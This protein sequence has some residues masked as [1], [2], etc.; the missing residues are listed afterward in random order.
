M[1]TIVANPPQEATRPARRR[2]AWRVAL[3]LPLLVGPLWSLFFSPALPEA[4]LATWS[5]GILIFLIATSAYTD[6]RWHRIYNWATYTA[7][8][9]GLMINAVPEVAAAL[10]YPLEEPRPAWLNLGAIGLGK[11]LLAGVVIFALMFTL[12]RLSGGG[13]GDVKLATAL[14]VHLG[15]EK[16]LAMLVYSYLAGGVYGLCL[17][18]WYVGLW[19]SI[20]YIFRKLGSKVFPGWVVPPLEVDQGLL[21]KR[22]PLGGFFALGTLVVLFEDLMWW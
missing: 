14:A 6:L 13:A 21:M 9:W 2:L 1:A 15:L 7:F 18:T 3:L 16:A 5:G 4:H 20:K 10:G 11:S 22:I 8:L 17:L 12:Y 19:S